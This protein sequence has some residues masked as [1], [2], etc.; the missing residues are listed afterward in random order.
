[1]VE[2][3]SE[4]KNSHL[5]REEALPPVVWRAGVT[6]ELELARQV[7]GAV[8]QLVRRVG[9]EARH[10]SQISYTL[11]NAD[12]CLASRVVIYVLNVAEKSTCRLR[13]HSV[14]SPCPCP[15]LS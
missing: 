6:V 10:F 7:E 13:P 2:V 8:K 1:M 15:L 3:T 12:Y 9:A 11:P 14:R 5:D 4:V